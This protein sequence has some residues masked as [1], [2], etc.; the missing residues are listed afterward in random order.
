MT[1]EISNNS[2]FTTVLD[3]FGYSLITLQFLKKN[4]P[5][6]CVTLSPQKFHDSMP[7]LHTLNKQGVEIFFMVNEGDGVIHPGKTIPRSQESVQRLT[8][9]FIDTDDC[10]IDNVTAFLEEKSI[11]PHL[12]VES[13]PGKYHIYFLLEHTEKTPKNI[14]KWQKIQSA[15]AIE[16][17]DQTMTDYAKVLRVPGFNHLKSA[18]FETSIVTKNP[19]VPLYTLDSLLAVLNID[20]RETISKPPYH[21]STE[22]VDAGN[23]HHEMSAFLGSLMTKWVDAETALYAFH[24]YAAAR[25]IPASDW[26]PGGSRYAEVQKFV[27]WK[28]Q[29]LLE[30]QRRQAIKVLD[31]E[32]API[33]EE[34]R[35]IAS[36]SRFALPPEFYFKCPGIVG[37]MTHQ[38]SEHAKY[39]LPPFAFAASVAALGTLKP[40]TQSDQGHAASNFFLCLA[41][42]GSGKNYAQEVISHTFAKLGCSRLLSFGI[43]S[44]KGLARYLEMN[45]HHGMIMLDEA[46][47]FFVNLKATDSAS[48][49]KACKPLLLELYTS[50]NSPYKSLGQLGSAKEAPIILKY[51]R[52][53]LVAHGVVHSLAASFDRKA[54]IDGLL[55]RFILLT[56]QSERLANRYYKP[57]EPLPEGLLATLK[58]HAIEA[59]I[60]FEEALT[61][62]PLPDEEPIDEHLVT[63]VTKAIKSALDPKKTILKFTATALSEYQEYI[64]YCD[65]LA[66]NEIRAGTGLEGIYTRSAEQLGRLSVA[67]SSGPDINQDVV[68]YLVE[69]LTSRLDATKA[70]VDDQV[71][72]NV[73]EDAHL[74]C[75]DLCNYIRKKQA[76]KGVEVTYKE[77]LRCY[78]IRRSKDLLEVIDVAKRAGMLTEKQIRNTANGT[79]KRVYTC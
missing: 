19:T 31:A 13:S 10:P 53:N 70:L 27:A 60:A 40:T 73:T 76:D 43:P 8:A 16:N 54:I 66:N 15:L 37:E 14:V 44:A 34:D 3:C 69:F 11:L 52:L 24:G 59:S 77:L 71:N 58:S 48:Y 79:V 9:C 1:Q 21:P 33:K 68:L 38:I 2:S 56:D 42:S 17:C 36:I 22:P 74:A 49:I 23:R 57:A 63:E 5:V 45:N 20:P 47:G 78:K 29:D 75:I 67:V 65:S 51:P 72:V 61:E 32:R 46:E 39:P 7:K 25:F 41:P 35:P 26:L 55:Q 4:K 6:G 28:Q 64:R 62:A 30:E 12:V 50:T 18:P